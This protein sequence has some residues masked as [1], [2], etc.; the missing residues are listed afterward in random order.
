MN[1]YLLKGTK[2]DIQKAAQ[3]IKDGGVVGMPTETVYGLAADALNTKAVEKI[4]AAKGRPA[5]N[6]LIV[7]IAEFEDIEKFG[8][9]KEVP[10][11]AR[12]LARQF[13]P[14]PLT[15]IM[16][17]G[18]KVD[19]IVTGGLDTVAIRLPAHKEA[20][21]LI[22]AAGTPLAAPSANLS[23]SPSPTTAQHVMKDMQGRIEA[24]IDGGECKVGLESTVIAITNKGVTILRPG[25][26]TVE[27]LE[28]VADSVFVSGAVLNK[29]EEG[30]AAP[31][32][33]MKYKHYAPRAKVYLVKG[34]DEAFVDFVNT[35]DKE[36][37]VAI[38]Y[39]ETKDN[40]IIPTI[41]LGKKADLKEQAHNLF[42]DLRLL[43]DMPE[44]KEAYVPYPDSQGVGMAVLNR[45]I[46]A[47]GFEVTDLEK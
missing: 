38:C 43:D 16:P 28:A 26:I 10:K 1:T 34:S 27:D 20:R 7:H 31:S 22:K 46:R 33:G 37:S 2:E 29:L 17:K 13:W 14:G 3:I 25:G 6:P 4:F 18:D 8:L 32:P 30:Q 42:A 35:K 24:V 19:K 11:T 36:N 15:I 45:L 12:V 5:D 40:I 41:V 9:V 23:G 44:V 47:A 39:E 21:E